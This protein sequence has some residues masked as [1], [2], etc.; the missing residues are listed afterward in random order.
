MQL[1]WDANNKEYEVLNEPVAQESWVPLKSLFYG[2]SSWYIQIFIVYQFSFI[3]VI[4]KY[5]LSYNIAF[6][7]D[8]FHKNAILSIMIQ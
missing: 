7:T 8:F 5:N 6:L 3:I 1:I 4:T 2:I